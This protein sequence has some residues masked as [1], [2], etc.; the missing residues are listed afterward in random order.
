M[1]L[2]F[3]NTQETYDTTGER[4]D[5][6]ELISMISPTETPFFSMIPRGTA[7]GR[8]H[9]WQMDSLSVAADNAVAEGQ[10]VGAVA[11][12]EP[13]IRVANYLQI[14]TKAISITG[15][16]EVVNKAGR[17]SELSYQLAKRS[18]ELKRDMEYTMIGQ[19]AVTN[20]GSVVGVSG[21]AR[22]SAAVQAQ[23]HE[24]WT[25]A[26]GTALP[27]SNISRGTGAGDDG[28]WDGTLW[29]PPVDGTQ[30]ALLESTLK[31][32][33][34]GAW[35]NGG[36]PT[37]IMVGPFNKT[38]ISEM[39]G[40]STRFDKGEDRRLVA[41]IDIYES[42]FGTHRVVP[43]RFTRERDVLVLTP[44]LFSL[45]F[46]RGFR[47]HNLAKVGDSEDRQL[48]VEWTSKLTNN[49]GSGIIADVNTGS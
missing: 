30:R 32:V 12:V 42:D 16:L 26:Y 9:E 20:M 22:R 43:N 28:G 18:K 38:V 21:T 5:L 39:T 14:S 8:K 1:A 47:Q 34:Q 40:G 29:D 27:G 24:E 46:L 3:T 45:D 10:K 17:N 41:A 2:P 35:H 33:I 25:Q 11:E 7:S 36:D 49:A 31:G 44:E 23:F 19:S 15:T 4:E 6:T 48:L 13:T 37:I